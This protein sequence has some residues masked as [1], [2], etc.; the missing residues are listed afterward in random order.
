MHEEWVKVAQDHL[1]AADRRLAAAREALTKARQALDEAERASA[2]T[3]AGPAEKP[4]AGAPALIIT[5]EQ[6][7]ANLLVSESQFDRQARENHEQALAQVGQA[8]KRLDL[9][10]SQLDRVEKLK[11]SVSE[12]EIDVARTRFL[13]QQEEH[14]HLE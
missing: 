13:S 1:R 12:Q 11:G 3:A 6:A 8:Q 9:A 14:R 7:R 4:A 2:A 5:A 10:K